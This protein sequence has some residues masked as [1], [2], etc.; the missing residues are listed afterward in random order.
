MN[1]KIIKG[2]LKH[3]PVLEQLQW[4][5]NT[6]SWTEIL[7]DDE[8]KPTSLEP[9]RQEL[10]VLR[11]VN[12]DYHYKLPESSLKEEVLS[13]P[14]GC[15]RPL[16]KLEKLRVDLEGLARV[17][18]AEIC[19]PNSLKRIEV[20]IACEGNFHRHWYSPDQD[21]YADR[22][23]ENRFDWGNRGERRDTWLS[24]CFDQLNKAASSGQLPNLRTLVVDHELDS[25]NTE[26]VADTKARSQ[27]KEYYEHYATMFGRHSILL[28]WTWP[29]EEGALRS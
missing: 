15:F 13:K 10:K 14:L 2:I 5:L 29:S 27:W 18:A 19:L 11:L 22:E 17:T 20:V 12:R 9:G 23:D 7:L 26:L 28:G 6:E 25:E 8:E 24:F 4:D 21:E 3:C 1:I 16:A